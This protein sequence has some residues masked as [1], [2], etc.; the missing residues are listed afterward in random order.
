MFLLG[1]LS[2]CREIAGDQKV[3]L[4]TL[5][6]FGTVFAHSWITMDNYGWQSYTNICCPENFT[7]SICEKVK[8]VAGA[9]HSLFG[10][11]VVH[12]NEL[13]TEAPRCPRVLVRP[14][15]GL[16]NI[17][18]AIRIPWNNQYYDTIRGICLSN[19]FSPWVSGDTFLTAPATCRRIQVSNR[20]QLLVFPW[21]S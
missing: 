8:R 11:L 21:R 18:P 6:R 13:Y 17:L 10:D 14:R 16:V 9:H 5:Q 2:R 4:H 15:N 20:Y 1:R 19:L 12:L 3:H 7:V